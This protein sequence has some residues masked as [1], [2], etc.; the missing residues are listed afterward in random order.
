MDNSIIKAHNLLCE[1]GEEELQDEITAFIEGRNQTMSPDDA[2]ASLS[3]YIGYAIT[4]MDKLNKGNY[5]GITDAF[6]KKMM[7]ARKKTADASDACDDL[8]DLIYNI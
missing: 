5:V 8:M 3:A 2:I 4:L 6:K 1:G 7:S